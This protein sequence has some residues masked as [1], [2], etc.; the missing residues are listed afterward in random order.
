MKPT[1][2]LCLVPR[3]RMNRANTSTPPICFH[4]KYKESCTF[5]FIPVHISC[6]GQGSLGGIATDYGLDGLGM[7]SRW[8]RDFSLVQTSP[9]AHPASC[10]MST[11][12][13]PGV[14][15]SWVM[16]T[17]YSLLAPRSWKSRAITL[18]LSGPQPGL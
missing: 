12:S 15:C 6:C 10:T 3:L 1:T 2:H 17:P 16:T 9:G 5:S 18:P 4:G 8:G 14:K 13:F 11:R 7:E